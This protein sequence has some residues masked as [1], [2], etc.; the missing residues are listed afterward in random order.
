MPLIFP[1]L[2]SENVGEEAGSVDEEP[3]RR[4]RNRKLLGLWFLLELNPKS[5][6]LLFRAP[7]LLLNTGCLKDNPDEELVEPQE[8]LDVEPTD[9][10]LLLL[11]RGAQE[12][13]IA[14]EDDEEHRRLA[15]ER[16]TCLVSAALDDDGTPSLPLFAVKEDE[17]VDAA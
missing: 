5:L 15:W 7:R 16:D 9:E 12:A 10:R 14:V 11:L 1:P 8:E 4:S 3:G 17:D 2:L 13:V 6:L